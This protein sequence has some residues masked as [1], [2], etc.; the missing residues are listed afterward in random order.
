M[1]DLKLAPADVNSI[2]ADEANQG[3]AYPEG[4]QIELEGETLRKFAIG[5]R[6]PPVGT[7]F[8]IMGYA[9]V[10]EASKE[11]EQ[12]EDTYC[13]EFQIT[14]LEIKAQDSDMER[15]GKLYNK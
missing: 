6:L 10:I 3:P 11:M 9:E 7:K 1:I 5:E 12:I 8:A 2:W 14:H 4:T 13:L 15:L